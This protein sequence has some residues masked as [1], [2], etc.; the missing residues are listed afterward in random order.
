MSDICVVRLGFRPFATGDE[1]PASVCV[2]GCTICRTRH[3]HCVRAC[4]HD[5]RF[6]IDQDAIFGSLGVASRFEG[7]LHSMF[8]SFPTV[9]AGLCWG[10]WMTALT[11]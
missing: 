2:E 1:S 10:R 3:R 4:A 9:A 6:L 8:R 11:R 7:H 5:H